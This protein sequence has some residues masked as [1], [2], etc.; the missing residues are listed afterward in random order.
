V[1]ATALATAR[2]TPSCARLLPLWRVLNS[3][4]NGA[5][6]PSGS[7]AVL[8]ARRTACELAWPAPR[9]MRASASTSVR[10]RCTQAPPPPRSRRGCA[11]QDAARREASR[12][13]ERASKVCAR[14]GCKICARHSSVALQ[15]LCARIGASHGRRSSLT[16]VRLS[17]HA[18]GC[19][20]QRPYALAACVQPTRAL[21]LSHHARAPRSFLSSG[22][23]LRHE[24]ALRSAAP[25]LHTLT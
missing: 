1:S 14:V 22:V 4:S 3:M 24:F 25:A 8:L 11:E 20:A 17:R 23:W 2:R 12:S 21:P 7:Q 10:A 9:A 5:L 19:R 18:P 13:A 16:A 15:T 6:R